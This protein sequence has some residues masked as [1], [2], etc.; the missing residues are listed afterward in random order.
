MNLTEEVKSQIVKELKS[1]GLSE[2]LL[3]NVEEAMEVKKVGYKQVIKEYIDNTTKPTKQPI[4]PTQNT[5]NQ[6][7]NS[8]QDRMNQNS[9]MVTLQ[10]IQKLYEAEQL[11]YQ[12]Y[13]AGEFDDSVFQQNPKIEDHFHTL[14]LPI[15]G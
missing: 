3:P 12:K 11:G 7:I 15:A 6:A 9:Q 10:V 14:S 5:N 13:F 4:L 2:S 8:F 1:N